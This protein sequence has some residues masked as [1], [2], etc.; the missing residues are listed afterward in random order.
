[1]KRLAIILSLFVG[2]M[3]FHSC[4]FFEELFSTNQ[5]YPVPEFEDMITFT[6]YDYVVEDSLQ[7]FSKF[8]QVLEAADLDKTVSAYNPNGNGYTLF[9]PTDQA[10][11]EFI[12]NSNQYN[13]FSDLL[14]DKEYVSAF[15]RFHVVDQAIETND[16]PFGALPELNLMGQSLTVTFVS[17]ADT[18]YYKIN[19]EAPISIKN[20]EASNGFI[21]VVT[22]PLKPLTYSTYEWLQQEEGF[23]I[24]KAAFEATGLGS[25]MN[26]K[27]TIDTENPNYVTLLLEHDSVFK[28][29][30]INSFEDLANYLSPGETDYTNTGNAIYNFVGY[31]LLEGNYFISDFEENSSNYNTFSDIPVGIDGTGMELAIN[32]AALA[33]GDTIVI[34]DVSTVVVY[35]SFNYDASNVMTQSGAVHFLDEIL[36]QKA[37]TP[38]TQYYEFPNEPIFSTYK[39]EDGTYLVEAHDLLSKFTWT[40]GIDFIYYKGSESRT[41]WNDGL[42]NSGDYIYLDGDFELTYEMP[43]IIQ[44]EYTMKLEVD[45]SH[46]SNAIV[47]VYVDGVKV[48]GL[49]DL[50]TG[51]SSRPFLEKEVGTVKFLKYESHVIT[52][53]TIIPGAFYWDRLIFTID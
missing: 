14:A 47:E 19:N 22:Y 51:S 41:V 9:L 31:H 21:H 50:T 29:Y 35:I 23:S 12:A 8:L 27:N 13:S 36:F 43:K 15:A 6:I 42:P 3:S 5:E 45:C 20:I 26:I 10:I 17:E 40:E 44:G 32:R 53:K 1:M 46:S 30:G 28:H 37:P 16:F 38:R 7:M 24:M 4:D 25:Q 34:G 2:M 49:I 39:S 52:I 33:A 11:D 48:G 18:S